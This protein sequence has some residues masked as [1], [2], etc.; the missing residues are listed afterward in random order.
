MNAKEIAAWKQ[1]QASITIENRRAKANLTT[2]PNRLQLGISS[3]QDSF[4][5]NDGLSPTSP[6]KP[7]FFQPELKV[8]AAKR[9]TVQPAINL[10]KELDN[11]RNPMQ[12]DPATRKAM[13]KSG[14]HKEQKKQYANYLNESAKTHS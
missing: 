4:A 10:N 8:F 12:M 11:W 7:H 13:G 5:D 14:C 6:L 3:N 2:A 1:R 9:H